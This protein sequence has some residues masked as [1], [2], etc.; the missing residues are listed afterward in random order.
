MPT[1]NPAVSVPQAKP[2]AGA[3]RVRRRRP[4][5][6]A[7]PPIVALQHAH[8]QQQQRRGDADAGVG[9]QQTIASVGNAISRMRSGNIFAADQIAEVRHHDTPSGRARWRRDD[10][11]TSRSHSGMSAGRTDRRPRR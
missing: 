6:P 5:R 8:Q 4:R 11:C 9:R 1:V 10:V 2:E 3:A 7:P